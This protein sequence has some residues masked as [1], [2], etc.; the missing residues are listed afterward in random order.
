MALDTGSVI[1]V[2]VLMADGDNIRGLFDGSVF[3]IAA[4]VDLIRVHDNLQPVIAGNQK[5]CH[6][7]PLN[8]HRDIPVPW[9]F[10]LF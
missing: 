7:E 8:F 1:V 10:S 3:D 6:A 4:R 5:T 9:L 2:A